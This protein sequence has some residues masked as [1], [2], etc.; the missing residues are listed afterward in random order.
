MI[1][2]TLVRKLLVLPYR[3]AFALLGLSVLMNV[4]P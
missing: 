3:A 1:Y 2:S 4:C